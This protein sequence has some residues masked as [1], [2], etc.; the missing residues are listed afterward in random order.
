MAGGGTPLREARLRRGL[1][2]TEVAERLDAEPKELR[3]LEWDRADLLGPERAAALRAA[4]ERLLGLAPTVAAPAQERP[5]RRSSFSWRRLAAPGL[6]AA[7][8]LLGALA[9][10]T[11]FPDDTDPAST[12]R[13]PATPP[14]TT[15]AAVPEQPASDAPPPPPAAPETNALVLASR[16]DSWVEARADSAT[17][18]ELYA[19]VLVQ[20]RSVRLTAG[21]VWLRLGAAANVDV[22]V[23]GKP[24]RELSGTVAVLLTPGGPVP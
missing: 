17:G 11:L 13:A 20:G 9:A 23:N 5:A 18:E 10:A 15:E 21:R 24:V 6:V 16:G 7:A 2:L 22:R 8:L 1:E 4:Y 14:T 19:G 12:T 3:A